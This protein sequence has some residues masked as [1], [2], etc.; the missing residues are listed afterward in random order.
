MAAMILLSSPAAAQLGDDAWKDLVADGQHAAGSKEFPKAEQLYLKAL[1]EAERFAIDDW[2]VGATLEG[3]GQVYRAEKKFTEGESAYKRSRDILS[4]GNG[5]D[6]IEVAN[7]DL[8]AAALLID[9]GRPADALGMA[10]R[11]LAIY[12]RQL[13]GTDTRTADALCVLGDSLRMTR[14]L[15]EAETALKRCASVRQADGGIDT[16]EFADA[17]HSLAL[18]YTGEGKYALAEPRFKLAEKI[19]ENKLGLTSPLLAQ[20]FEDHAAVLKSMGRS[21]EADRLMLLSAAIRRNEKKRT[22]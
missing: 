11:T 18:T 16:V 3:L 20:T 8:D 2:R 6:T 15:L 1:H 21:K 7:L 13:G 9:A 12:E 4:K 14:S 19:R 5:E 17:L 22:R 10:R